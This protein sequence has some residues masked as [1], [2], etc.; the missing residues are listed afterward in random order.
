MSDASVIGR[1]LDRRS[2]FLGGDRAV[3]VP[4]VK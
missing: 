3:S 2:S 4:A 1:C